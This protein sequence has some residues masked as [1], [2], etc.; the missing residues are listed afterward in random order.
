M[1][2]RILPAT[3][4]A[5]IGCIGLVVMDDLIAVK[6]CRCAIR[7]HSDSDNDDKDKTDWKALAQSF[8]KNTDNST[9]NYS[10]LKQAS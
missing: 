9:P 3:I 8:G 4:I 2:S 7:K 1:S 5:V 6:I 10:L